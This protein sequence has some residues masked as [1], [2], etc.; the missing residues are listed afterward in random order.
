MRR[1]ASVVRLR[2]E[3]AAEYRALHADVWPGVLAALRR[4]HVSNYSIFLRDG[5]LFSYLEYDG[6]DY[7]A[8]M[9][10]VAEDPETRAWWELTD[11][12][13]QPVETAEPG[14]WWAP[15]TEVFHLD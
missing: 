9:A 6:E 1:F 10:R 14:Q 5:V 13:Q 4:A 8:D 11:P 3:K 2:P 7:E 15:M 12:C